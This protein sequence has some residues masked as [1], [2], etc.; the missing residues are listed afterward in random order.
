[1]ADALT[2]MVMVFVVVPIYIP[3]AI[4]MVP[5]FAFLACVVGAAH[6]YQGCLDKVKVIDLGII[7]KLP[8]FV[9][10]PITE[11]HDNGL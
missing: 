4:G 6:E 11:P 8:V 5:S 1:M 10:L 9:S 7:L 2:E 3:R